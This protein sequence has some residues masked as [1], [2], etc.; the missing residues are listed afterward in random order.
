MIALL[1][2]VSMS[3]GSA[4]EC[5]SILHV[6]DSHAGIADLTCAFAKQHLTSFFKQTEPCV[7][8]DLLSQ[9]VD[10]PLC[11]TGMGMMTIGSKVISVEKIEQLSSEVVRPLRSN[12]L[13]QNSLNRPELAKLLKEL[14]SYLKEKGIRYLKCTDLQVAAYDAYAQAKTD[15]KIGECYQIQTFGGAKYIFGATAREVSITA[16]QQKEIEDLFSYQ[17]KP[18]HLGLLESELVIKNQ[19][20]V[21]DLKELKAIRKASELFEKATPLRN[22]DAG[23]FFSNLKG[24]IVGGD[25]LN[26]D[27]EAKSHLVFLKSLAQKGIIKN[28]EVVGS[29][30]RKSSITDF[31]KDISQGGHVAVLLRSKKTGQEIVYDSWFEKGGV[32]AHILLPD[33]WRNLSLDFKNE[34]RDIVPLP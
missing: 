18:Y 30:E 22:D 10:L 34:F 31:K 24:E 12:K 3:I 16:A 2:Y 7:G 1:F 8:K 26:C 29:I 4:Q 25:Q 17:S 19:L 23:G 5:K 14:S 28:F 33:E 6:P 27:L 20:T 11:E 15:K 32:A 9:D 21:A 13:Y